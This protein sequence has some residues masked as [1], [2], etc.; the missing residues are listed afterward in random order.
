MEDGN[1]SIFSVAVIQAALDRAFGS[2]DTWVYINS[3]ADS[4]LRAGRS[5]PAADV[6]AEI[7]QG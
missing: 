7:D 4:D 5:R 3:D 6:F 1:S 2:Y